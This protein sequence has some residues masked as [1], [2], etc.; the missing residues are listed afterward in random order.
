M[1]KK[2]KLVRFAAKSEWPSSFSS[3][4]SAAVPNK[5][6]SSSLVAGKQL[7]STKVA[8]VSPDPVPAPFSSKDPA[9]PLTQREIKKILNICGVRL[10]NSKIAGVGSS[11]VHA[12]PAHVGGAAS[13]PQVLIKD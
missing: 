10:M 1:C 5:S 13:E 11:T 4:T 3:A 2:I 9:I 7:S 6:N 8:F 12:P